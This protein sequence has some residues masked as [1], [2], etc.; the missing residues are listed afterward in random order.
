MLGKGDLLAR[1]AR[2]T[3]PTLPRLRDMG[4]VLFIM[5]RLAKTN[6]RRRLR[7]LRQLF[8]AGSAF[9][10]LNL[11]KK[12]ITSHRMLPRSAALAGTNQDAREVLWGQFNRMTGL[13]CLTDDFN[14]PPHSRSLVD[15][16]SLFIGARSTSSGAGLRLIL[17]RKHAHPA[18]TAKL[19]NISRDP[20][21][22][23]LLDN[24]PPEWCATRFAFSRMRVGMRV[25][26]QGVATRP[27]RRTDFITSL[28][29]LENMSHRCH[30]ETVTHITEVVKLPRTFLKIVPTFFLQ[31]SDQRR[32]TFQEWRF[33]LENLDY[34]LDTFCDFPSI[35]TAKTSG[36]YYLSRLVDVD[37]GILTYSVC[38]ITKPQRDHILDGN[39]VAAD[40]PDPNNWFI[41]LNT[42]TGEVYYRL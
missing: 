40:V 22:D 6:T 32:R 36:N 7:L 14:K 23:A 39:L 41:E 16:N 26:C 8:S 35:F 10:I 30:G 3:Q 37:S 2:L 5:T 25:R 1:L 34:V 11:I 17:N 29:G 18:L 9:C 31:F 21:S 19:A 28:A 27:A 20:F 12:Q 38:P 33:T 15:E 13:A 42:T 24:I 4:A